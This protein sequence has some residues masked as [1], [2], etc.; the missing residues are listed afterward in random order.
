MRGLR[1]LV[2]VV[3]ALGATAAAVVSA[4]PSA[5]AGPSA[6]APVVSP[7]VLESAERSSGTA[8]TSP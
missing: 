1:E 4:A 7:A 5:L 2:T 6:S 3:G 8:R